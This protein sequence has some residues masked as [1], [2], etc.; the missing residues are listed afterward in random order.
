MHHPVTVS[1]RSMETDKDES[2]V[3]AGTLSVLVKQQ[4][5]SDISAG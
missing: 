4:K 2:G 3:F 1:I 5:Q